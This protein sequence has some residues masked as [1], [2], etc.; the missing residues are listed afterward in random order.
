MASN[1]A[2]VS[3]RDYQLAL[4]ERLQ[5]AQAGARASSKLGLRMGGEAWLVDL[6]GDAIS[7]CREPGPD[8]YREIVTVSRHETLRPFLLPGLEVGVDE[9]LG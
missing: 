9:I 6:A 4:S 8:G 7:V 3:L 5:S 1:T 2:R